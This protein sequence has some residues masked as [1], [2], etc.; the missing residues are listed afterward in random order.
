MCV[1]WRVG[2]VRVLAYG[3]L[4]DVLWCEMFGA[5]CCVWL[6]RVVYCVLLMSDVCCALFGGCHV[7]VVARRLL[8]CVYCVWRM[9]VAF[10]RGVRWLLRVTCCVLC[11][12]AWW[13]FDVCRYVLSAV[14]WLTCIVCCVLCGVCC[15][16]CVIVVMLVAG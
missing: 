10:L 1:G 9:F 16:G 13:V 14:C 8:I 11:F 2:C 12:G 7:S 15:L 6:R 5:W 3:V 4:V